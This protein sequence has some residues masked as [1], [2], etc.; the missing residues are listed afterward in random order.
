M[1]MLS[2]L[3][4]PYIVLVLL[5]A[6]SSQPVRAIAPPPELNALCWIA[7]A[8]TN[9]NPDQGIYPSEQSIRLDLQTL[10]AA[11]FNGLVTYGSDNVLGGIVPQVAQ[12]LGFQGMIM[13]IWSP[14][15]TEELN[16]AVA[17]A[18]YHVIVGYVVGNEGLGIRY[19]IHSLN[20]AMQYIRHY[21]GRPVTTTEEWGDYQTN[22]A[23]LTIGDWVYPNVHPYYGGVL[24]PTQAVHWTVG[25]YNA[26]RSLTYLP[27]VFK[28]VGLPSDGDVGNVLSEAGQADYYSQLQA[29]SVQF[30]FFEAFNQPWKLWTPVEPYWGIFGSDR[31]PKLAAQ[32]V[33]QRTLTPVTT[34]TPIPPPFTGRDLPTPTPVGTGTLQGVLSIPGVTLPT[35]QF[36]GQITVM[37]FRQGSTTTHYYRPFTNEWGVFTL[38]DL[39]STSYQIFIKHP[40][41]LVASGTVAITAG[42]TAVFNT[43]VLLPADADANGLIDL[44]DLLYMQQVYGV[45]ADFN[46]DGVID[47]ADV[48]L[49]SG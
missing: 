40:S 13:G 32:V 9:F 45:N 17:A 38:I 22:A 20:A 24:D 21:T 8:P 34:F 36:V 27:L 19:D 26:L 23:L 29:T 7:Y 43:G 3:R 18:N 31:T 4:R 42:A 47:A 46:G 6:F 15:N 12:E 39:P 37:L 41:G 5:F 16:N 44:N 10:R 14:T 2:G 49:V 28:E 30:A 48:A 35:Q 1:L 25:I 33:C 11:G